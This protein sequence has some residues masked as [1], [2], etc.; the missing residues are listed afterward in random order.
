MHFQGLLRR[1]PR[2]GI[3]VGP[4]LR[5]RLRRRLRGLP[6]GLADLC[7]GGR[8]PRRIARGLLGLRLPFGIIRKAR[9]HRITQVGPTLVDAL[10][11]HQLRRDLHVHR[12]RGG[13]GLLLG[14][15]LH[16]G[17]GGRGHPHLRRGAA[18]GRDQDRARDPGIQVLD[19]H[20]VDHVRGVA[21]ARLADGLAARAVRRR[22]AGAVKALE[23]ND[24]LDGRVEFANVASHVPVVAVQLVH[25]A[26]HEVFLLLVVAERRLGGLATRTSRRSDQA[27][28]TQD[29]QKLVGHP[30]RALMDLRRPLA[31]AEEARAQ[32]R[33]APRCSRATASP[34]DAAGAVGQVD[35]HRRRRDLR[36][37]ARAPLQGGRGQVVTGAGARE[38]ALPERR[39]LRHLRHS[40]AAVLLALRARQRSPE[41][42]VACGGE[43][44]RRGR[45]VG[46][47]RALQVG[48]TAGAL[49]ARR[50]V[51]AGP[52]GGR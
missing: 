41:V 2:G 14:L 35:G 52:R 26:L 20:P 38:A 21:D 49:R 37:G 47:Q 34:H 9:R 12:E 44:H 39:H 36:S 19:G 45:G 7:P 24:R 30:T 31:V 6:V 10:L 4:R 18:L 46:A 23:G 51:A 13:V 1:I 17:S 33:V 50:E 5:P 29:G 48:G 11:V 8:R 32:A 15:L 40:G 42:H 3:G 28:L 22:L 16:R 25:L 27:G 43:R